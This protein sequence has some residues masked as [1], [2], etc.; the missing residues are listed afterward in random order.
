MA[1]AT[2]TCNY[3][4]DHCKSV[5]STKVDDVYLSAAASELQAG[6]AGLLADA[7]T[8]AQAAERSL[9]AA[10]AGNV[11]AAS[12][13]EGGFST[14]HDDER[15]QPAARGPLGGCSSAGVIA[16]MLSRGLSNPLHVAPLRCMHSQAL[17]RR[18]LAL[19]PPFFKRPP[20]CW[21]RNTATACP[22]VPLH[23]FK[24]DKLRTGCECAAC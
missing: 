21:T 24:T 23:S 22:Q 12:L 10:G 20:R 3:V 17:E 15:R 16:R 14:L 7:R 11:T 2:A 4:S 8:S 19:L 1:P 13:A 6:Q 5:M 9:G 18:M